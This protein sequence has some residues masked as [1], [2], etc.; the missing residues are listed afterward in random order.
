[1][2]V[3]L[4]G[5]LGSGTRKRQPPRA[6]RHTPRTR[7]LHDGGQRRDFKPRRI[8]AK[9]PHTGERRVTVSEAT[10]LAAAL[11]LHDAR[12]P[13]GHPTRRTTHNDTFPA[14]RKP[15]PAPPAQPPSRAQRMATTRK[16][17]R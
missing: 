3:G 11:S 7:Q 5:S 9:E 8:G 12:P 1:G 4:S 14:T 13:K 2:R 16:P 15:A 10:R 6:Q 17:R